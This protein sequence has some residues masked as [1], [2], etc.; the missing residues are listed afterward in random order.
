[1]PGRLGCRSICS[2]PVVARGW[3]S[4]VTLGLSSLGSGGCVRISVRVGSDAARSEPAA[5]GGCL[6]CGAGRRPSPERGDWLISAGY[7]CQSLPHQLSVRA[8]ESCPVARFT[9]S[10][11][12]DS[13][14]DRFLV[15][16]RGIA[17]FGGLLRSGTFAEAA[18]DAGHGSGIVTAFIPLCSGPAS[19]WL[20]WARA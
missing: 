19:P 14:A 6:V 15:F 3:E 4:G 18:H 12:H 20:V 2:W 9:F 7:R 13:D 16:Q 8:G 17:N 10:T 11:M 5:A 1:M